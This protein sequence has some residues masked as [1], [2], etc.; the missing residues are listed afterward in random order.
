MAKGT[1]GTGDTVEITFTA[2][3]SR[4]SA[5]ALWLALGNALRGTSGGGKK[6]LG[7]AEKKGPVVK[8]GGAPSRRR[9][10]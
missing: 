1:N 6:G 4:Q 10:P 2:K 9:R 8:S 3:I 5:E 7:A